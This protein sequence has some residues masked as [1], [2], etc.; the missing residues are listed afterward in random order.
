MSSGRRR[1]QDELTAID[2]TMRA[3]SGAWDPEELVGIYR[4]NI[5]ELRPAHG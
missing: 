5:N 3:V 4:E 1:R 2:R